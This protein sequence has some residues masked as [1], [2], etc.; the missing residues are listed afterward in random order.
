MKFSGHKHISAL[1]I[2]SSTGLINYFGRWLDYSNV[3]ISPICLQKGET[4]LGLYGLS[5]IKDERLGRLFRNKKVTMTKPN[6][7]DWVNLLVLHQNR[8]E[9][10]PKNFIPETCIPDFIDLVIWGHEHD[11]HITPTPISSSKNVY[12]SQPGNSYNFQL[13]TYSY[14][15]LF[16][17]LIIINI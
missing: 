6:T 5:H 9:R 3:V 13:I 12:V 7:N 8:A 1:D 16:T 15:N 17:M 2:I 4:K 14:S 10:G 11:C